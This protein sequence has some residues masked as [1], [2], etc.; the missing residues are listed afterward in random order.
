[1]TSDLLH[2][3]REGV[4]SKRFTLTQLAA[5]SGVSITTLSDMTDPDWRP[6]I[7]DR[8]ER[9]KKALD[10]IDSQTSK[11]NTSEAA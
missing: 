3:F 7:L 1:M 6:Q 11:S 4:S 9:L 10:V 8:L 5:L 2:R